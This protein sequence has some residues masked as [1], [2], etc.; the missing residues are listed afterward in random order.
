MKFLEK[1][2]DNKIK[3][4]EYVK[5]TFFNKIKKRIVFTNIENDTYLSKELSFLGEDKI[6]NSVF[7]ERG[8]ISLKKIK[9][10][11]EKNI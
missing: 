5:R 3:S 1:K 9:S 2:I 11:K 7:L 4:F 10:F 6:K 8:N